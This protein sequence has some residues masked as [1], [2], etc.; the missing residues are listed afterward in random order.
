MLFSFPTADKTNERSRLERPSSSHQMEPIGSVH[1][2]M[3]QSSYF[4]IFFLLDFQPVS[5]VALAFILLF[6]YVLAHNHYYSLEGAAGL[7][8]NQIIVRY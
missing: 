3:V 7:P 1:G 4:G 2:K 8:S 5:V 6:M